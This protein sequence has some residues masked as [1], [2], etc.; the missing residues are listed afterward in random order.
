MDN[1][2]R[3][4]NPPPPAPAALAALAGSVRSLLRL[5]PLLVAGLVMAGLLLTLAAVLRQGMT[6]AQARHANTAARAD[7]N[8]RCNTMAGREQRNDCRARAAG[9]L[10]DTADA[11]P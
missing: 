7:A 1:S 6:Q 2:V 5:W 11:R 3:I 10:V 8:F 4:G 9:L